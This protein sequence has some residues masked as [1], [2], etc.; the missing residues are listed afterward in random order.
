MTT[1]L[2]LLRTALRDVVRP[3]RMTAAV[4]LALLPAGIGLLWRGL[5]REGQFSPADAYNSLSAS[6]VFGFILTILSVIYGTGVVSQ[7][8]E[9]RTIVYL[10]T[11]P[12][13]RWRILLAK[14]IGSA[15]AITVT[16]CVSALLL[17]LVVYGPGKLGGAGQ[18]GR[19]LRI[20]PVGALAYGSVFLLVATLL[21]RPLTF[22][23]LFAFGWE[24]WVPNL[25]G[26]FGRLSLMAHL[27]ALAPHP[28][29]ARTAGFLDDFNPDITQ[30]RAWLVLGLVIAVALAAA[31]VVFSTR[32]YAPRED[33]E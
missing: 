33:A 24:S 20:L 3:K 12:V 13:P 2:F 26:S 30:P 19:D 5:V 9:Q 23:L 15:L 10:L 14:F 18:L 6:L 22:G 29:S 8:I 11:R 16:V 31:L 27:R 17:A 32:E 4:L 25:P 7:E 21:S 1:D 28:A